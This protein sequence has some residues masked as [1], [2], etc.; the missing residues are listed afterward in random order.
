MLLS[1]VPTV[2]SLCYNSEETWDGARHEQSNAETVHYKRISL[3]EIILPKA[4]L[5]VINE[6][7]LQSALLKTLI[8]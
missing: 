6:N 2:H 4:R 1:A 3:Q 5:H 8:L 7:H